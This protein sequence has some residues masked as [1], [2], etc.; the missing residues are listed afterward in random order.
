MPAP[1]AQ[2]SCKQARIHAHAPTQLY[3]S[4][5][6]EKAPF[7]GWGVGRRVRSGS[8]AML[9]P[10]FSLDGRKFGSM[11]GASYRRQDIS[12]RPPPLG[13]GGR[14]GEC[15]AVYPLRSR[16]GTS[17]TLGGC[18]ILWGGFGGGKPPSK[19]PA[20]KKGPNRF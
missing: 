16:L 13:G 17:E 8:S 4:F 3:I 18:G 6:K 5:L 2:P 1:I 20:D 15:V 7:R 19:A 10:W 11:R 14:A 12:K 9:S